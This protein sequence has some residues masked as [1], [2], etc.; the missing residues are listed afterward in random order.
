MIIFPRVFFILAGNICVG[1]PLQIDD[2]SGWCE[3][4][5]KPDDA[6]CFALSPRVIS[7]STI[8]VCWEPILWLFSQVPILTH[9]KFPARSGWVAH[10]FGRRGKQIIRNYGLN[11]RMP[12][13]TL[14][15]RMNRL[16]VGLLVDPALQATWPIQN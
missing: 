14:R 10:A 13:G 8:S 2:P 5:A 12:A 15:E 7:P 6:N 16:V 9:T 1:V 4:F 3:S 11:Q